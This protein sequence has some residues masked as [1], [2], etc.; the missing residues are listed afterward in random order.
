[1]KRI[2]TPNYRYTMSPELY[3]ITKN[4]EDEVWLIKSA[5]MCFYED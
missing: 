2:W 3:F 5:K 1:M 4:G